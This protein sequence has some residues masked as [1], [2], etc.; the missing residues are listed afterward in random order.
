MTTF[1][2]IERFDLA[3]GGMVITL[4]AA[5]LLT[6]LRGDQA[7]V[8]VGLIDPVT[9]RPV[10]ATSPV[11]LPGTASLS[12]RF[13]EEMEAESV[14]LIWTPALTGTSTWSGAQLSFTPA[15]GFT[16]GATYTLT[17]ADGARSSNGRA[18]KTGQTW[19]LQI[20]EPAIA[21]LYPALPGRSNEVS[22]LFMVRPLAKPVALTHS[23]A[24]DVQDFAPS[25]D[26]SRIAFTQNDARGK[27][28]LYLVTVAD[29]SVQRLT[30]CIDA[31][32]RAP[33]WNPDGR[34]LVYERADSSRPEADSRA[35]IVDSLTLKT[36]PLFI[37]QNRLA[38]FPRWSADGRLITLYDKELTGIAVVDVATGKSSLIQTLEDD[39]GQF[40]DDSSQLA[41]N[42]LITTPNG[43]LRG[44][45]IAEV[46][47]A[48]R[49]IRT[50]KPTD[51]ALVDDTS[52][53]WHPDGRH[54]AVMR[55]YMND[56]RTT[57]KYQ[58][59]EIDR[60]TG[61]SR[62]LLVAPDYAHGYLSWSAD[63]LQLLM[64]RFPWTRPDAL[65]G[66][67]IFD[68]RSGTVTQVAENG[69]LPR[70]LP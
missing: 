6:V 10:S 39:P 48:T 31:Y 49:T 37:E 66:I 60:V 27:S 11:V 20:R 47:G 34:R 33:S 23:T 9:D 4:L 43:M 1:P 2:K 40:S 57:E 29:Q 8:S 24:Q 19:R 65:P 52:V 69:Y 25:P 12:L 15:I 54:L 21:Y 38:R 45:E 58:V 7:G 56:D 62:P 32:C 50:L 68:T 61:E 26:G 13:G 67:W 55:R 28:D 59:Y 36:E 70:W 53:A 14:R 16:G 63:G 64:Q 35:W 5:I 42:Q 22:N 18:V 17:L 44:L 3:I 46:G 41:Y 30:N 51:G